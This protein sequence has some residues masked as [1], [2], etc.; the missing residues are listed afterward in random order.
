[1]TGVNCLRKRL[2]KFAAPVKP[3]EH[4]YCLDLKSMAWS[5]Q[6]SA[7]SASQS[8]A[9]RYMH[10]CCVLQGHLVVFGGCTDALYQKSSNELWLYEFKTR[11]WR[12]PTKL[13][14]AGPAARHGHSAT[15]ISA[16][17]MAVFGGCDEQ[18]GGKLRRYNDVYVFDIVNLAWSRPVGS[19]SAPLPRAFHSAVLMN[20][21]GGGGGGGSSSSSSGP[22]SNKQL[23]IFAGETQNL[24][25]DLCVLDLGR[26]RWIRPLFDGSFEHQMHACVVLSNKLLSFGGLS[27]SNNVLD[28]FFFVNTV[29]IHAGMTQNDY[30]FKLVLVG[31]SAVGKSCLMTRFVEDRYSDIHLS[32]IGVDFKTVTTM[33]DGKVVKL[34]IWDTAGQERFAQVTTHYYRGADGAILVY[35]ITNRESFESVENW[36]SAIENANGSSLVSMLLVGNKNDLPAP[37]QVTRAQAK[38]LGNRLKAHCIETSAKDSSNVDITFLNLAKK[39]V[40]RRKAQRKAQGANGASGGN[41]KKSKNTISLGGGVNSNGRKRCC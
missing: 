35:D 32:T 7:S 19:G 11:T 26:M 18:K 36:V 24:T 12:K 17:Q 3:N 39:L 15:A 30:T 23:F 13:A 16:T 10:S 38:A 2:F 1:M 40:S 14:G 28:D 25:S 31:D 20:G 29:S 37:R 33:I 5:L 6:A 41:G 21:G 34:H 22:S 4:L 27:L 8:P 9:A